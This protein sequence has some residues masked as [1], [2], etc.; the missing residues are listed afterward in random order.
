MRHSDSRAAL[1]LYA[2]VL[3]IIMIYVFYLATPPLRVYSEAQ[4]GTT[5]TPAVNISVSTVLVTY[6]HTVIVYPL[7]ETTRVTSTRIINGTT[8]TLV[9]NTTILRFTEAPTYTYT[10]YKFISYTTTRPPTLEERGAWIGA[11]VIIGI[12]VGLTIGYGYYG[13]GVSIRPRKR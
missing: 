2:F 1:A 5:T 8:T 13:K 11:G 10:E 6:T 7:T 4:T 12:L 3:C 9:E